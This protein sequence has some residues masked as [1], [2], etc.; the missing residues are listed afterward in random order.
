MFEFTTIYDKENVEIGIRA[1]FEALEGK[2]IARIIFIYLFLLVAL[3][4]LGG[5]IFW[6]YKIGIF[7]VV[8]VLIASAL[9]LINVLWIR[10]TVF[11]YS[12]KMD[13]FTVKAVF[14][15]ENYILQKDN[16]EFVWKYEK[17]TDIFENEKYIVILCD[18]IGCQP[19]DK[20]SV[21]EDTLTEF[22]KFITAK[23][24]KPIEDL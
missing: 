4:F 23:T 13:V 3:R 14:N 8:W 19:L 21:S 10:L 5:L 11:R 9:L 24:G 18:T 16:A 17:V 6:E 15:E 20:S 1:S 2:G 7:D 22:R 12:R